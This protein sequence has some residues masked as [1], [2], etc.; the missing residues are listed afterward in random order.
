MPLSAQNTKYL[1]CIARSLFSFKNEDIIKDWD[2]VVCVRKE[3]LRPSDDWGTSDS[4]RAEY[5]GDSGGLRVITD[6]YN[7]VNNLWNQVQIRV[8]YYVEG[9]QLIQ[10]YSQRVFVL[11]ECDH[12]E[13]STAKITVYGQNNTPFEN[14]LKEIYKVLFPYLDHITIDGKLNLIGTGD[15]YREVIQRGVRGYHTSGSFQVRKDGIY[16]EIY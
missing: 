14:D 2:N 3:S 5:S 8:M 13:D 11:S 1:K 15:N 6:K 10:A 7:V 4:Y 16:T 9:H 12:L